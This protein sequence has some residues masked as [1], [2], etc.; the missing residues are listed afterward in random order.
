MLKK[1]KNVVKYEHIFPSGTAANISQSQNELPIFK[2]I[3]EFKSNI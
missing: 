3:E 2:I 1:K